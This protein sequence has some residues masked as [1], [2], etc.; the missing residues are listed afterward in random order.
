MIRLRLAGCLHGSAY[1]GRSSYRVVRRARLAQRV[2]ATTRSPD[3]RPSR[4]ASS[5]PAEI[6]ADTQLDTERPALVEYCAQILD[7]RN[8][9]QEARGKS[10][11][12]KQKQ[13]SQNGTIGILAVSLEVQ[14]Q[15]TRGGY[16]HTDTE[17]DPEIDATMKERRRHYE[18]GKGR[19][20]IPE[21]QERMARHLFWPL[22]IQTRS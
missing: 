20:D 4:A 6:C 8:H 18:H 17:R 19:N 14:A 11:S 10:V 16:S 3:A 5:K 9:V 2:G 15:Q 22:Q 21:C 7:H 13:S 1:E 12:R